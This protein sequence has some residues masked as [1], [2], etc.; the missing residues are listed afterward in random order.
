M[1]LAAL[2]LV[3]GAAVCH[4]AWN[5]LVKADARRLEIQSG[6]LVVGVILCSP[7]LLIHPLTGVSL[8]A[9]GVILLSGVLETAY[10]FALTAAYGAGDLSLVYP[11]ARGTPPLLVVPLAIVLLGERP[12]A[13]GL[14][15]IG[16]VILGIYASHA[17]LVGGRP[18]ARANGRALALALLTGVFT[19]GY[20]LVNKV[21]VGLVPVPLYAF[22]VFGVDAALIHLVRWVRGGLTS[23]LGH[24]APRGRAVAVGVLM[25]AAYLAVLAAMAMAPVSYVVAAREVSVVV[26]AVL[27]ALVLRERHSAPRIA[28]AAVIFAGLVVIALAR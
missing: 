18:A 27:G 22:L 19:A 25:M 8:T 28:G 3:L 24:D 9:W 5:L 15:G 23:P 20:S 21:G 26:T 7:A 14:A 4:S 13:Q 2:L 11:V 1:P 16:L 17:G 12:S 6:A 10:V